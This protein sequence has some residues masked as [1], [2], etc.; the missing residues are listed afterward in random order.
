MKNIMRWLMPKEDKI[1]G[2]LAMQSSNLLEAAAELKNFVDT[3][4]NVERKDRKSRYELIKAIRQKGLEIKKELMAKAG[5]SSSDNSEMRQIAAVL[6]DILDLIS[7]AAS[8][9]VVLGIERVDDYTKK[10]I[11]VIAD[12]AAEMNSA[13]PDLKNQRNA[14]KHYEK[15]LNLEREANDIYEE[16]LSELFHFY[17]NSI[18]IIKY[19]E[20]YDIFKMI[21]GKCADFA[22]AASCLSNKHA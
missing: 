9:F 1:L 6:D 14:K 12:A 22:D 20:L 8:K 4:P 13:I 3:Y 19:K 10:F 5:K 15:I 2:M 7:G 21:A 17:K 16:A 18:D 11:D